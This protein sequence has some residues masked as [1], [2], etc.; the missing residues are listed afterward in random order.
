MENAF[1]GGNGG[2]APCCEAYSEEEKN[3]IRICRFNATGGKDA[4]ATGCPPGIH[5]VI[6][7]KALSG[8][9]EQELSLIAEVVSDELLRFMDRGL[10]KGGGE[11]KSVLVAGL[12]NREIT[13]D[14][15][16]VRVTDDIRVTRHLKRLFGDDIVAEHPFVLSAL[17]CGVLGKTG[18]ETLELISG[19]VSAIKPD[20]V[21]VID[22][23][24]ARDHTRL[25]AVIQISDSGIVPGAGIGNRR[26]AINSR[27]L[28]VPVIA[29]GVPTVVSAATLV[30]DALIGCGEERIFKKIQNRLD[31]MR[32]LFV[33]PKDCDAIVSSAA[34]V[35]IMA[36]EGAFL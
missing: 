7:T 21:V 2:R 1:L 31:G 15:F 23:L 34:R 3:G 35:V 18:I 9:A 16:G 25:G 28:G 30:S 12:G 10:T 8:Y 24:A 14:S 13:P 11:Q 27:T 26:M 32:E 29:L 20:A 5:S 22:A 6:Y 4:E 19:A 33:T 17:S 36:L